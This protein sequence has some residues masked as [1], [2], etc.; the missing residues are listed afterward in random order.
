VSGTSRKQRATECIS[1]KIAIG[2]RESGS[3]V[4]NMAKERTSLPTKMF[5]PV[6]MYKASLT[7]TVSINGATG[8][9]TLARSRMD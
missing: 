4:L 1:G 7:D 3:T 9:H 2:M 6:A 5:S 8:P